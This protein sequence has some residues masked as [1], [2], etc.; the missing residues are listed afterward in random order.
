M[1][2][3]NAFLARNKNEFHFIF[4]LLISVGSISSYSPADGHAFEQTGLSLIKIL[5][6]KLLSNR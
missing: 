4:L 5:E 6:L 2:F 3:E 1:G